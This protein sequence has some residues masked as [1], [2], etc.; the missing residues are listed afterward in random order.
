MKKLILKLAI[1]GILLLP[2]S[3]SADISSV[4]TLQ[5]AVVVPSVVSPLSCFNFTRT[6]KMGSTS[7][8]VRALQFALQKEGFT[9]SVSEYGTFGLET[10]TALNAFQQKYS[11]DILTD[12]SLPT[13]MVGVRTRAK[14]NSIYGCSVVSTAPASNLPTNVSM[15]V[16]NVSLDSNGITA[17]FCNNSTSAL[18]VFPARLRVN[19]IVRD[20]NIVGAIGAGTCD[21]DLFPYSTWGLTYDPGVT[22]GV[23]SALDPNGMYK[24]SSLL[25]PLSA[26][27]TLSVP[28]IAGAHLSIRGITLKSN[29]L[30]GTFCNLGD[31]DL[32]TYPVRV[33]MNGAIKDFDISSA[34]VHGKCSSM[35]W[36]YDVWG[37]SSTTGT[38]I[39]ATVNVDPNNAIKESNEFD[40]SATIS[41]TL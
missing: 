22:Y 37:V 23:V 19:G 8:D 35:T 6:L 14:L 2:L 10:Q 4:Q 21:T 36:S 9:I 29:G 3:A 7:Y 38:F 24:K 13:G 20:F 1:G 34:Y 18:P 25:Y 32:T 26:T 28:A 27:T 12:G 16:K 40:N 39:N 15:S 33:T 30:Q 41:G 17:V 31:T 11:A 5:S